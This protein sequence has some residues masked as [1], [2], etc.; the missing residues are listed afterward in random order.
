MLEAPPTTLEYEPYLRVKHSVESRLPVEKTCTGLHICN[1]SHHDIGPLHAHTGFSPRTQRTRMPH[2]SIDG[3]IRLSRP[4]CEREAQTGVKATPLHACECWCSYVQDSPGT[5]PLPARSGNPIPF[6]TGRAL[7]ADQP[8]HDDGSREREA[9]SE[10]GSKRSRNVIKCLIETFSFERG[11]GGSTSSPA[12]WPSDPRV[13]LPCTDRRQSLR[14][15]Q[16]RP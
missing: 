9:G 2:S 12:D 14:L 8:H 13:P 16:L 1:L 4:A 11:L 3:R 5:V 15:V 6:S 7:P 10:A